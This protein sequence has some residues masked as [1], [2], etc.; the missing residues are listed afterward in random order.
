RGAGDRH[1]PRRL[2]DRQLNVLFQNLPHQLAG[3]RRRGQ[4][5][6]HLILS[7]DDASRVEITHDRSS[8]V[9]LQIEAHGP[10][11]LELEGKAPVAVDVDRIALRIR[12][13]ERMKVEPGLL[14]LDQRSRHLQGSET[15]PEA[16]GKV[17]RD[18]GRPALFEQFRKALVPRAFD[19][20]L[21]YTDALQM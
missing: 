1:A 15:H 13:G 6:L 4:R 12:T 11:V 8:V 5:P 3:M 9:V 14:E 2:G 10:P 20:T 21:M 19:H 17:R 7:H 18:F 16:L